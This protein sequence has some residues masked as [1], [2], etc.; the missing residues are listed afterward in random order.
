MKYVDVVALT[1]G[2]P[3][4][5]VFT[6]AMPDF[7]AANLIQIGSLVAVPYGKK[8]IRGVVIRLHDTAPEFTTRPISELIYES[9]VITWD[10]I[11]TAQWMADYYHEPL[12]DCIE[13]VMIF[14]KKVR[15]PKAKKPDKSVAVKTPIIL[16]PEQQTAYDTITGTLPQ[17]TTFLLHGVTGSGKTEVY[18][19]IM[20]AVL[21]QGKQV[22]YLVPE[23]ALTPQ[24]IK[25]VEERFPGKTSVLNSQVSD[26]ERY[27]A[28]L[29][30]I[31]GEKPIVIGS[32]S[33]LFAPFPD[34]GLII[35]DEA[36]DH[37]FKQEAS[38]RYHAVRT[39]EAIAQAK[40]IPLILGS[41]TPRV[42][43][44]YRAGDQQGWK[45]LTL[46]ARAMNASLPRVKIV[47]MREELK[48]RN[49]ST[50]SDDLEA[51]LKH[52]LLKSEQALLFLN[53]R[54]V[55]SSLMCRMCG[56]T[57]ECP[58][59]SIALTLHKELFG[60]LS[61][62][63]VCHHCDY[64]TK[65]ILQCPECTSLYIKPLGSGTERVEQDILK[66][67][68]QARI[69][70]M[71]RDTTTA[72]GS[73]ER[74]YHSFLNHEADI[75]IG[76]QM[77]TKGW[78]IPNVTMVGIVNA[79]T[80]LHMPNYT[81][82]ENSF[83]LITQV[84]GRAGRA[85]KQ[86]NVILQSYNPDHYAVVAAAMHDYADFYTKEIGFRKSLQYPPFSQL[87]QLVYSD[88]KQEKAEYKADVLAKKLATMAKELG[89]SEKV[90]ILG[91]TTGIIP[92]LRN[93]WYYTV[94]LKGSK[95]DLDQL[96]DI[97]PNE[98]TIDVDPVN[99]A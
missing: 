28:F 5:S 97:V 72:K 76:T 43:D 89:L 26:G 10:L 11:E 88:E 71:D 70:R 45:L 56:W 27:T 40:H 29:G 93:K 82:A 23:I 99:S 52:T 67:M 36:H 66:I 44:Y 94:L 61:N 47:D 78:D 63:L 77:I 6:Y 33:A 14:R 1:N 85:D 69:L 3:K 24:T 4:K 90:E 22:V 49:F 54:G 21:S 58:R 39:A 73:H 34:L 59:C 30:C 62:M 75:L 65:L 9:P 79:D 15:L 80:A 8:E 81:S 31:T 16:N 32:R 57:A 98:W 37:S 96:I 20:E 38:P 41:A 92:R 48:K 60:E 91:P 51:A 35:V 55:A 95:K 83:A 46:S 50:L 7:E 84:A 87:V 53:K 18:L 25:R 42:E 86:G 19:R 64:Q 74:I 2:D 17:H 13:T 68:P 12:R